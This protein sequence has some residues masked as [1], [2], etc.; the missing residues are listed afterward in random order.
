MNK[1]LRWSSNPEHKYLYKDKMNGKCFADI[2]S[3]RTLLF[4]VKLDF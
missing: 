2:N 1:C 4:Y 3:G